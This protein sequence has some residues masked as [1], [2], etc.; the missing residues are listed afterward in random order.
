[1]AGELADESNT[2][3]VDRPS[4]VPGARPF[5]LE[6]LAELQPPQYSAVPAQLKVSSERER[7]AGESAAAGVV[8]P[9][10][11]AARESSLAL[12]LA[13]QETPVMTYILNTA[14]RTAAVSKRQHPSAHRMVNYGAPGFC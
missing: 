2:E 6:M 8:L 14:D 1:L 3:G 12:L 5:P 7:L 10:A 9:A 13:L 4:T 11:G